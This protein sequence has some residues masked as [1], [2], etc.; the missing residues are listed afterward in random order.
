MDEE[1]TGPRN[2]D[3]EGESKAFWSEERRAVKQLLW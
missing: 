3:E 2:E 1:T